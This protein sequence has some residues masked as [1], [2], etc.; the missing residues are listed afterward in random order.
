[1]ADYHFIYKDVEG[2]TTQWDDIQTKLGNLPPKPAPFKP[3]SF[4]PSED[5]DSK[6]K[7]QSWIDDKTEEELEDL[8]D[9]TNLDDDRFLEEYRKKRLAEMREVAKVARFGSVIPISGADFVREV[10]QAPPDVW[11]VVFLFKE[12]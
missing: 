11:V 5:S 2:R 7:D 6:P 8:E 4:T 3:P 9:D 12:G 10:S 1:M